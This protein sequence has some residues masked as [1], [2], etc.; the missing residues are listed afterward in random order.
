MIPSIAVD[1]D[2]ESESKSVLY[3]KNHSVSDSEGGLSDK[4]STDEEHI[5][6]SPPRK[7]TRGSP[8]RITRQT[9]GV[10]HPTSLNSPYRKK[11]SGRQR[12][13]IHKSIIDYNS[14][15]SSE[16]ELELHN[17]QGVDG[18]TN[19]RSPHRIKRRGRPCKAAMPLTNPSRHDVNN[20]VMHETARLQSQLSQ[21]EERV[22]QLSQRLSQTRKKLSRTAP[23]NA[24][25][26]VRGHNP[27]ERLRLLVQQ[28][29]HQQIPLSGIADAM[30]TVIS[31][32]KKLKEEVS[33]QIINQDQDFEQLRTHFKMVMYKELQHK[34]RPW[35]C[36]QQIDLNPTVS[37]RGYD[38]IRNVEFAE[39]NNPR[40]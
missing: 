9:Q 11:R 35:M 34:F 27:S 8:N 18:N 1:Y 40:Y 10:N 37:F 5:V 3:S 2:E 28:W 15:S 36:L 7:T 38:I 16:S 19:L 31:G 20:N 13:S 30:V 17:S 22:Q 39:E 4:L 25:R 24:R 32:S 6:L 14:Y 23:I 21:A 12:Q 26:R 29:R 33:T